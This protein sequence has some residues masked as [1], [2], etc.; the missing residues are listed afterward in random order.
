MQRGNGLDSRF[1]RPHA[2]S[3][4]MISLLRLSTELIF[5]PDI[6]SG[7]RAKAFF[8][9]VLPDPSA[10]GRRNGG[11]SATERASGQARNPCLPI[12]ASAGLSSHEKRPVRILARG[13]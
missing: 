11:A 10:T 12:G 2:M 7:G 8:A 6:E 3:E 9:Y 5:L 13:N 1:V 4:R